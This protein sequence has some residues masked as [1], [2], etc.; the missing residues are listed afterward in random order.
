MAGNPSG[1]SGVV[2]GAGT[3]GGG[4][5]S[6]RAAWEEVAGA[7]LVWARRPGHDSYDRFH[8]ARF[9]E[10]LPAPGRLTVDV[11]AGE[12]RLGRDLHRRGHHVIALDASPTLAA[13][14]AAHEAAL[15]TVVADA[16]A[17]PLRTACA[18]LV[19]AFMSL[20]DVDDLDSS[21]A[22][23]SR[24]LAEAGRFCLAVVHPLNSA[25]RFEGER[26]DRDAP[27]VVRGSYLEAFRYEDRVERDGLAMR[28][29]S[30]HRP[31]DRYAGALE[32]AGLVIEVLREVSTPGTADRWSRI[33][34]FL[35]I[36]AVRR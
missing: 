25:G 3:D 16:A 22:E 24:L 34:Y 4:G 28:F 6:L 36:R 27:F 33:P 23:A 1:P 18:D 13:A 21:V 7:W 32:R 35:H 20:Q 17:M 29:N 30:E 26:D 11:G 10:L 15:P 12:G 31:I 8:A 19:V 2:R 9:L 5:E 14:C